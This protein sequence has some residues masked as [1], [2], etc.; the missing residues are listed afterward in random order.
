MFRRALFW[1][2]PAVLVLA[3]A[4][5]APSAVSVRE[6]GIE[7]SAAGGTAS[8]ANIA[9]LPGD[10]AIGFSAWAD[11]DDDDD[12]LVL[13]VAILVFVPLAVPV[14]SCLTSDVLRRIY[15]TSAAFPRGPPSA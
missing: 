1:L 13:T 3:F 15:P 2:L 8:L 9:F 4:H 5:P 6:T 11:L 10:R 14:F 7:R 12:R